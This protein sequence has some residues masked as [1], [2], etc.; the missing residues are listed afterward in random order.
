MRN[1]TCLIRKSDFQFYFVNE[2]A[3]S[4]LLKYCVIEKGYSNKIRN[5][6]NLNKIIKKLFLLK[7]PRNF[8]YFLNYFFNFNKYYGQIK[9]HNERILGE[10]IIQ[11]NKNIDVRYVENINDKETLEYLRKINPELIIVHGTRIID[12]EILSKIK[13]KKINL[14]WGISP[15]YR[16]EG[17][18]TALSKNDFENL[19]VTIHELDSTIDNGKIISQKTIHIDKNDNFYSIGIKMTK[20]GLKILVNYLKNGV[21]SSLQKDKT[22][23]KGILFDSKY[24]TNNYKIFSAAYK[25]ILNKKN[26]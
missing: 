24:I 20:E 19:G 7:N 8:F 18:V 3:K 13:C 17:I 25:N 16:G 11:I 2:L 12:Q 5:N 23:N 10:Q 1:I 14:H 22:K 26:G 4:N 21:I 15:N 9:Y 6:F